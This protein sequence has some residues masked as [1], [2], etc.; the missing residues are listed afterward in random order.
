MYQTEPEPNFTWQYFTFA[1]DVR[2]NNQF[3]LI[4]IL[5]VAYIAV[6]VAGV[7][8]KLGL[9]EAVSARLP[10]TYRLARVN[11]QPSVFQP[12]SASTRALKQPEPVELG[13][14]SFATPDC[15][16]STC[17]YTVPYTHL[18]TMFTKK[19]DVWSYAKFSSCVTF[20]S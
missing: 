2:F 19:W 17:R 12:D 4:Y 20:T 14:C 13:P 15:Q 6:L 18:Y 11:Q 1:S 5:R 8:M 10:R 3:I 9:L 16:F 7:W